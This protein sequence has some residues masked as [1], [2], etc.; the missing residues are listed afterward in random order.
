MFAVFDFLISFLTEPVIESTRAIGPITTSL[1]VS[2]GASVAGKVANSLFNDRPEVPDITSTVRGKFENAERNLENQQDQ[3]IDQ[4]QA[5]AAA[6]GGNPIAA[7]GEV[8]RSGNDAAADLQGKKADALSKARN[9]ERRMKY[10]QGMREYQSTAQGI[11]SVVNAVSQAGSAYA[12]GDMGG[13]GGSESLF[14]DK[15]Q[16]DMQSFANL[17][18]SSSGGA[19]TGGEDF[20][21]PIFGSMEFYDKQNG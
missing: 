21:N 19:P 10:K 6:S 2:G 15:M 16:F 13:G 8:I 14:G 11:G 7:M 4:V 5:D 18:A 3:N 9:Q 17:P 12:M 1:L 20:S